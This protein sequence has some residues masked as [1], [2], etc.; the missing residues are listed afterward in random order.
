MGVVRELLT[1]WGFSIDPKPL[2]NLERTVEDVKRGVQLAGTA[3][4]A[5][6]AGLFGLAEAARRYIDDLDEM[7][8]SV[9]VNTQFF[10][11][12]TA[13]A[14]LGGAE[15]QDVGASV[16]IL[17]KRIVDARGGN[18]EAVKSFK[19]LGINLRDL[20]KLPTEAILMK[21]ADGLKGVDDPAKRVSLALDLLGRGGKKLIPTLIGGS[22]AMVGLGDEAREFG[23]VPGQDAIDAANAMELSMARLKGIVGGLALQ[24]GTA[25]M[26]VVTDV[27]KRLMEWV[28]ANRDLIATRIDAFVRGLQVFIAKAW[29][30]TTGFVNAMIDLAR[31]CR[32]NEAAFGAI[33]GVLVAFLAAM[34]VAKVMQFV[35]ALKGLILTVRALGLVMAANPISAIIVMLAMTI[36]GVVAAWDDYRWAACQAWFAVKELWDGVAKW[37]MA[38]IALPLWDAWNGWCL[39]VQDATTATANFFKAAWQGVADWFD[40]YVVNPVKTVLSAPGRFG[41]WIADQVNG[42]SHSPGRPGS[43]ESG[44]T[45]DP[46]STGLR[47]N[48][49]LAATMLPQ[50]G[51]GGGASLS[52][53]A[54]NVSVAGGSQASASDIGA[55][56]RAAIRDEWNYLARSAALDVG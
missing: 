7:A 19:A 42:V 50:G 49:P 23:L 38:T 21:M 37:F 43:P 13:A 44:L 3:V 30:V 53:G 6:A 1:K 32:E 52:V 54:I 18:E 55:T 24:V 14:K 16:G 40:K 11:E 22:E 25:L 45:A 31:W 36:A 20:K 48:A 12:L 56:V 5:A 4:V 9:G 2:E 8:Q 15:M 51:R 33:K 34:A 17:Q 28:K 29:E 46:S 10:A 26:P 41:E 39:M 35:S 27:A 47:Y